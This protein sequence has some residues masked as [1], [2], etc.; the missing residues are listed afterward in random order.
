MNLNDVKKVKKV[1]GH[2][3][4]RRF[5]YLIPL[6]IITSLL[7]ILSISIIIPFIVAIS[8][9]EKVLKSKYGEFVETQ[10]QDYNEFLFALS[11]T[12][13][14]VSL[15]STLLTIYS[16]WKKTT[17]ANKI[18]QKVS[19]AQYEKYLFAE[20]RFHSAISKTELSKTLMT[21]VV[22]RFTQNVLIASVTMMSKLF[23]LIM[24]FLFMIMVNPLISL[25]LISSS[26]VIYFSI[27]K[28]FRE[29]LSSNGTTIS[30]SISVLY[31]LI[32][33]SL[34]GI[35]ETK[36][37]GLERYY[38]RRYV[39]SS[40][41]VAA[42]TSSSQVISIV[43][44]SI[45]E[46][47]FFTVILLT[48]IYLNKNGTLIENLPVITFFLYAGY[49]ALPAFQ[50]V[51]GSSTLIKA[52]LDSVDRILEFD[53]IIQNDDD[54]ERLIKSDTISEIAFKDVNFRYGDNKV[55]FKDF[56]SIISAPALVAVIGKS[57][58]GKST[59]ID[60]LLKLNHPASGEVLI[61]KQKF[62]YGDARGLFAYVPQ[63][64]YLSDSTLLDNVCL[65]SIDKPIDHDL[66]DSSFR[67]AGL[68]TFI[69]DLPQGVHTQ[70]GENGSL[71]SGGQRKRLGLARAFY[72]EKAVLILDE[73]TSG[74][75][76]L[77]EANVMRVLKVMSKTKL[78]ILITHSSQNIAL[79]DQ[80]ID[81]NVDKNV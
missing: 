4:T 36:F 11:I 43:P 66:V 27:Y 22:T 40:D 2:E 23:F 62:T 25:C 45:I 49:R 42:R 39:E 18:G 41:S 71:L 55:L 78:I 52:N 70:V 14:F 37:Y 19:Q 5:Y 51:Y 50:Q 26:A 31:R 59:L 72:S 56:S 80:V 77:T 67:L 53:K 38:L 46:S 30:R 76:N 32:S 61:N 34:N 64:I 24:I 75:D 7:E 81:L 44:K 12:L 33:E 69:R 10:F 3:N 35:K 17:L 60:L 63:K 15:F 13:I 54:I 21:E 6:D 73:V 65:G 28:I 16:S 29:T 68:E 1:L 8:D 9:P 48:L 58:A 47:I 20:Y 74:L 79:F 57:G